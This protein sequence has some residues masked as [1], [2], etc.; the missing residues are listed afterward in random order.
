MCS[1]PGPYIATA[2]TAGYYHTC[3]M[4]NDARVVCWGWNGFGQL[5]IESK[6]NV[7]DS[8]DSIP[9]PAD[10]GIGELRT[11]IDKRYQAVLI[12]SF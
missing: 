2:L 3:A 5:G 12:F 9:Q 4:R 7:G 1:G 11:H 6:A 8:A 10:I